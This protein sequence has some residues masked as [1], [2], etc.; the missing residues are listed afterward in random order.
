MQKNRAITNKSPVIHFLYRWRT[1]HGTF[2]WHFREHTPDLTSDLHL[3]QVAIGLIPKK[4]PFWGKNKFLFSHGQHCELNRYTVIKYQLTTC[5]FTM[6]CMWCIDYSTGL[7]SPPLRGRKLLDFRWFLC[8]PVTV[9]TIQPGLSAEIFFVDHSS[10]TKQNILKCL[11]VLHAE[12]RHTVAP[13]RRPPQDYHAHCTRKFTPLA[14]SC[15]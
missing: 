10:E 13:W 8:C 7:H 9:F 6:Y 4:S 14:E 12:L 5:C 2:L 11:S 3:W 15:R 1:Q